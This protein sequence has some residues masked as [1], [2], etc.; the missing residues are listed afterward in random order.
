MSYRRA[1]TP[2]NTND[3]MIERGS[4]QGYAPCPAE[5]CRIVKILTNQT[6]AVANLVSSLPLALFQVRRLIRAVAD[7]PPRWR[8]LRISLS[9]ACPRMSQNQQAATWCGV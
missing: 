2:S 1:A 9:T 6:E 5:C 4:S 8:S 3:V 7:D